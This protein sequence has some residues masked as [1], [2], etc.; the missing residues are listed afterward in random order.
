MDKK[1][2][3][4]YVRAY[5]ERQIAILNMAEKNNVLPYYKHK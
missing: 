4:E 5:H 3:L 1:R 2:I